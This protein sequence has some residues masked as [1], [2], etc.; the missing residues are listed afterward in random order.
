MFGIIMGTGGESLGSTF[1]G[2][3]EL[4][5]YDD[6][7]HGIWGMSYKYHERAIVI[8]EKN[9]VRLW[10]IGYDGYVGGKGEDHVDWLDTRSTSDFN[11]ATSNV[12][13]PYTGASMMVM[14]FAHPHNSTAPSNWPSPIVFAEQAGSTHDGMGVRIS[15]DSDDIRTV[16]TSSFL[17]FNRAPYTDTFKRY[18]EW[19]PDFTMLH[20]VRKN[21]GLATMDNESRV[22]SIAFQGTMRTINATTQGLIRE[23]TGSGHHGPDF[24]GC[25]SVRAGKGYKINSQPTLARLA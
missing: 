19:M 17:V 3:T 20:K 10:D 22:D 1:W 8:N 23:T 13:K 21:A 6:S 16:P 18:V 12:T 7:Q 4:S 5:C 9:L 14:A 24:V 2:Q 11:D 25:A 15:L